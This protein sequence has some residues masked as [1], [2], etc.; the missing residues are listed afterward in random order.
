MTYLVEL[1]TFWY[2]SKLSTIY[3]LRANTSTL[4]CTNYLLLILSFSRFTGIYILKTQII[5]IDT[6]NM[7]NDTEPEAGP[8]NL[9][10]YIEPMTSDQPVLP[11]VT[12][13]P[14]PAVLEISPETTTE[15][16]L[17][18]ELLSALG[19][20]TSDTPDFGDTVHD[21]LAS[22][23]TPLLKKGLPKDLKEDLK[24]DRNYLIPSNCKM[25][26]APRLNAEISAAV[27]DVVRGRDKKF[28]GFQ[29][30]LGM[31][32]TAINRAMDT[33]LSSDNKIQALKYLSD[34]CRILVDLHYALTKDR[35]KLIMPSLD[36]N[37]LHV[38]QDS[39]RDDTLFNNSLSEKIKACKAIERQ[40]SQIRKTVM[41]QRSTPVPSSISRPAP[42]GNWPGPPRY[43][44]HRGTRGGQNF[45]GPRLAPPLRRA[46]P[47]PAPPH[48]KNYT[49][50]RP[51]A[52]TQ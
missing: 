50:N 5:V 39:E 18:P 15:G 34:G 43:P 16:P 40:G 44:S 30:Q 21:S 35:I 10:E 8:S 28:C 41:N 32:T 4:I 45:R 23:W 38:I 13:P 2:R 7:P 47:P 42:Q 49:Q 48:A 19:A 3:W 36:K 37:F 14:V 17:D 26:Q 1:L 51:R 20:S 24:K 29:Q 27:S 9:A 22:L 12:E 52:P 6:I 25:L 11:E 46:Y 33:L 31:G